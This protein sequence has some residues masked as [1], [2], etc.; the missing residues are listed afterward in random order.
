MSKKDESYTPWSL[1]GGNVLLVIVSGL[2][3]GVVGVAMALSMFF[4]SSKNFFLDAADKH[5]ISERMSSRLGG[6]VVFLG[7]IVFSCVQ[8]VVQESSVSSIQSYIFENVSGFLVVALLCGAVGLWEDYA[9]RLSP[10]FRLQMLFL[11]VSLYFLLISSGLPID[12]FPTP[13]LQWL[14]HPLAVGVGMTICVVG[15]INAGNMADG[16]NGLL[17]TIAITVF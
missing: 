17:S 1:R 13:M 11:I 15:F 9:Q 16:A 5:G 7:A 2:V 12:I 14:N 6:P 10:R 3:G 8:F 4:I